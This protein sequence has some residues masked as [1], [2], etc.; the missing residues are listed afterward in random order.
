ME[1]IA[2][3]GKS[4]RSMS[5]TIEQLRPHEFLEKGN[6]FVIL[7]TPKLTRNEIY[8]V[9]DILKHEIRHRDAELLKQTRR[10]P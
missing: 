8:A 5:I 2:N 1:P 4:I 7:G 9:M 3:L 6:E 10:T